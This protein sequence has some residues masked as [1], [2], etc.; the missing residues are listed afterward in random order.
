MP[1]SR[2]NA[3]L[4]AEAPGTSACEV[5]L[6]VLARMRSAALLNG[7]REKRQ[8]YHGSVT[9]F[10]CSHGDGKSQE[11]GTAGTNVPPQLVVGIG[12]LLCK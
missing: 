6:F 1:A 10:C 5:M 11:L 12:P 8:F 9:H 4:A 2:V 3:G 7:N